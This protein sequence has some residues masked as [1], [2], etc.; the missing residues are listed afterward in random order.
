MAEEANAPLDEDAPLI[1]GIIMPIAEMPGYPAEHW[2]AM[3]E[4]IS[5]GIVQAG[6]TPAPVWAR[7]AV[8]V[9]HE[10]IVRNLYEQPYA[11]CDIS[12]LNPNVMLELGIRLAFGKPTIIV[13][14]GVVRAPF[15]IGSIE[16]VPYD[17]GLQFLH[18]EDFAKRLAVKIEA[19]RGAKEAGTDRPF[20][21]TFGPIDLGTPG[22]DAIPFG[23]A[24]LNQ[25]EQLS[26]DIRELKAKDRAGIYDRMAPIDTATTSLTG[27]AIAQQLRTYRVSDAA[28]ANAMVQI[29]RMPNVGVIDRSAN[30]ITVLFSRTS[31]AAMHLADTA[32]QSIIAAAESTALTA[33][34]AE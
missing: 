25:L 21:K 30:G 5:R 1:C 10:R 24:V 13:N 7:G 15:D 32:V 14:D 9:L 33:S 19:V 3:L 16:Y 20:I 4:L 34:S 23:K 18:A 22:D 26:A 8:D 28:A 31:P 2:A 29:D 17:R 27:S 12:G 11:V 6:M